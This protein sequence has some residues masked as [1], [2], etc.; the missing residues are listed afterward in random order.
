MIDIEKEKARKKRYRESEKGKEAKKREKLKLYDLLVDDWNKMFDKQKGCCAICGIH[1]NELKKALAVDHRHSD[2]KVRGLL[3]NP[4]NRGI[5]LLK[6]DTDKLKAA[7][8]YLEEH[9]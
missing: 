2:G 9:K 8:K 4:C 7:I 5:G 1:Q 6:E 3:C